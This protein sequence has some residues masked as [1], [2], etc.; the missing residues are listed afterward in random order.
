MDGVAQGAAMIEWIMATLNAPSQPVLFGPRF[1]SATPRV[2]ASSSPPHL[3]L[4]LPLPSHVLAFIVVIIVITIAIT[5]VVIIAIII[6]SAKRGQKQ[7]E[8]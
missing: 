8:G 3:I 6:I 1:E 7:R 2:H 4:S 5:S